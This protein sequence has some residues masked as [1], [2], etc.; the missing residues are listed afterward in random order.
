MKLCPLTSVFSVPY[1]PCGTLLMGSVFVG[2]VDTFCYFAEGGK[3][4]RINPEELCGEQIKKMSMSHEKTK[5]YRIFSL[6]EAEI[7]LFI[8]AHPVSLVA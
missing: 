6:Y 5:N 8:L 7:R 4:T 3:Q 1:C 2:L